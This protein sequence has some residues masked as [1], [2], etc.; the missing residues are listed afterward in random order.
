METTT[1]NTS[2][3]CRGVE[4]WMRGKTCKGA[5]TFYLWVS[6]KTNQDKRGYRCTHLRISYSSHSV[7]ILFLSQGI[8]KC[9]AHLHDFYWSWRRWIDSPFQTTSLALCT[10]TRWQE[11]YKANVIPLSWANLMPW[12]SK[13]TLLNSLLPH[14]LGE[15]AKPPRE[16]DLKS[17]M[18]GWNQHEGI[19][20]NHNRQF[21][22]D[23]W[24][25]LP[26]QANDMKLCL[27]GAISTAPQRARITS[28]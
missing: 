5:L 8:N 4:R 14:A 26:C 28:P 20:Q 22:R 1:S 25:F 6:N 3:L 13:Q 23:S 24:K 16:T 12:T 10:A 7:C 21:P 18:A 15:T 9:G 17:Q 19:R 27:A 11:P 2:E